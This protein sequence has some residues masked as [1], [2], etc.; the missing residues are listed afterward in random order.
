MDSLS[1]GKSPECLTGYFRFGRLLMRTVSHTCDA[2]GGRDGSRWTLVPG[3]CAK[4]GG[5]GRLRK[6]RFQLIDE[7]F[8]E[9]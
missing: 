1:N 3:V 2:K 7:W 8:G 4:N 9:R 6:N 5:C